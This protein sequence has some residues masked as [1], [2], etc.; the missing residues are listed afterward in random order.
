MQKLD[1]AITDEQNDKSL[2]ICW[3]E[4]LIMSTKKHL[5]AIDIVQRVI[6][7]VVNHII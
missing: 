2:N 6:A 7:N 5:V 3:C 1:V 4:W